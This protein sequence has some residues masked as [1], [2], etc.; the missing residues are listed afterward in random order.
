MAIKELGIETHSFIQSVI[1]EISGNVDPDALENDTRSLLTRLNR[2]LPK[3][4]RLLFSYNNKVIFFSTANHEREL[5]RLSKLMKDSIE[6][7]N[8]MYTVAASAGISIG[9][10]YPGQAEENHNKA[11]QALFHLKKQ[12][13]KGVFHFREMGIGRLFLN[14]QSTEI[15]S[16]LAEA[17]SLLWTDQEKHQELLFTLISYVQNNASMAITAKVLHIHPNTLYHRIKK[18]EDLLELNFGNY[19]DFLKVQL[20]V[21]LYNSFYK[22]HLEDN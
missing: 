22:C 11:E 2:I 13:K 14:H 17:F 3:E 1:I 16:F 7:W 8:K 21:Y 6:G 9:Q 20:A 18:I 15:E 5:E 10:Y 12:N 4:N 19:E